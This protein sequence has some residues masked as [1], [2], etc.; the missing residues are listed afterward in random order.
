M[1]YLI[2]FEQLI[3][4]TNITNI[5]NSYNNY[6]NKPISKNKTLLINHLHK[7][8]N[9]HNYIIS[10]NNTIKFLHNKHHITTS[11]QNTYHLF[12][13][14]NKNV[15]TKFN[16]P[17]H[18]IL[19]VQKL[20]T[21]KQLSI[22][23]INNHIHNILQIKFLL[24]LFD[25]PYQLNLTKTDHIIHYNNHQQITLQTT[26]KS[27]ILL[28]NT[29]NTLPLQKNLTSILIYNPNTKKTNHYINHYNP[30]IKPI[31]NI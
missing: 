28:K 23:I 5:I 19:P 1:I 21:N 9:F 31:I 26:H 17:Q 20:I 16:K 2:P 7:H 13:K 25:Q 18:F 12:L 14:T 11:Y 10:N 8:I 4:K 15:H 6:N 22:Q 3:Q 29:N 27:I 24:K 30:T